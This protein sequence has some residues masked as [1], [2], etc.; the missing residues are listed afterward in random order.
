MLI[1]DLGLTNVCEIP[2]FSV[3]IIAEFSINVVFYE[4]KWIV[5]YVHVYIFKSPII[6]VI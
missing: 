6:W 3:H 5:S 1:L 4:F 2:D